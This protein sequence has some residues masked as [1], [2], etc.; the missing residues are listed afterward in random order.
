MKGSDFYNWSLKDL[1][2]HFEVDTSKGLSAD[3]AAFRLEKN[4]LN[5]L[6][7]FREPSAWKMLLGQVSQFFIILLAI[8]AVI[9]YL[10]DGVLQLFII[11]VIIL[12]NVLLGFFQEYKAEKALLE[13]KKSFRS[14]S[15]VQRD[16][17]MITIDNEQLVT[18]DIVL[19][20]PG[21]KVPADLR[22]IEAEGLSADESIITGESLPVEKKNIVFA[23]GTSLGDRKNMVYASTIITTGHAR[24]LVVATGVATEFGKIAGLIGAAEN[25]TSL[26]KQVIYLGKVLTIV[27]VVLALIVFSLGYIRHFPTL[28]LLTFTI[29]LLVAVVPE[30]L[31]TAITLSM[32]VG[33][34]RMAQK[35]AIVRKMGAIEA[36]G[37]V[38][39]IATDKTGTLTDNNLILGRADLYSSRMF[40]VIDL[41]ENDPLDQKTKLLLTSFL[42]DSLACSSIVV[43]EG[44]EHVGDPLEVAIADAAYRL[45]K[46]ED[47]QKKNFR[48]NLKVPFDSEKQYMA[49]IAQSNDSKFILAKGTAEKIVEFCTLSKYAK[50]EIIAHG[51]SLSKNG[52]KVIALASKK[53]DASSGSALVGLTF[54]GFSSIVDQPSKGVREAISETL[55]AHI[56]P[57]I[58]TGDHP[59]TARFVANQVG[60]KVDDDE[61]VLGS[62]LSRHEKEDLHRLLSKVKIF[63]RVTPAD[64]INIVRLMRENGFSVAMMGDG[65][66]DAPALRESDVGIAMG[67]KGTDIAKDSADIIL[68]DDK[69]ATF[70]KAVM[71]GRS[72][73]DN[74][75][76]VVVQLITGNF[77]EIFLVFV[78]FLFALPAPFTTLQILWINLIIESFAALSMSIEKPGKQ[79]AD[80][81]PRSASEKSFRKP[82]IYAL[83]LA[84]VSFVFSALV[85]FYGLRIS[86]AYARTLPFC[87]IVFAELFLAFS[88]RSKKRFFEDFSALF[89]NKL[90]VGSVI[91]AIVLQIS[92]VRIS[93]I[94][95]AFGLVS[96]SYKE[97]GLLLIPALGV[98]FIAEI[99]RYWY[100]RKTKRDED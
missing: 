14:R 12:I 98:F 75:Q 6:D 88:I 89:E 65:V 59:E 3:N 15:K 76:N 57:V 47:F 58:I 93:P 22:I 32:A 82:L 78:A 25:K 83:M 90:L 70:V 46:L 39:V 49:V 100:D 26:E 13:L 79:T 42:T 21:D 33:V 51:L 48:K 87:F 62:D 66:N 7:I 56:R 99:I 1:E 94:A 30:S 69:Y 92:I 24:G 43:G 61:I 71:F 77:N 50:E 35:K 68:S 19:L 18:G 11:I 74:I 37:T 38:N 85:Y 16:G 96:L 29:A 23:I 34:S 28:E 17:R 91:I 95:H 84:S 64:K 63:A 2:R 81:F 40:T 27:A 80:D 54:R 5:S 8:A 53:I 4:G 44:G 52:F 55:K 41:L 45:D 72:I 97:I 73:Y 20:D 67:I 9:S 31:P 36:L 10:A 86:P 60:L